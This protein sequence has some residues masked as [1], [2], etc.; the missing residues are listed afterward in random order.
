[1]GIFSPAQKNE[2]VFY[3][4]YGNTDKGSIFHI[5]KIYDNEWILIFIKNF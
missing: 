2:P 4:N 5:Q 1:M 3:H